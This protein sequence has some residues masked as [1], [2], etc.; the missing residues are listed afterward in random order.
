[1]TLPSSCRCRADRSSVRR[2]RV[3]RAPIRRRHGIV[4]A[5][6]FEREGVGVGRRRS[7]LMRVSPSRLRRSF[8]RQ[9]WHREHGTVD[10]KPEPQRSNSLR[11][12]RRH[13]RRR[14]Q[15]RA[16]GWMAERSRRGRP[17][18][19]PGCQLCPTVQASVEW[20]ER[21]AGRNG[22]TRVDGVPSHRCGKAAIESQAGEAFPASQRRETL[23][24]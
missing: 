6:A 16:G 15:H 13:Q 22:R 20:R 10:R 21:V 12:R 17:A 24:S 5:R 1:M 18:R 7:F 23:A 4:G 9:P 14:R 19:P 2:R 3:A 11:R 8:S